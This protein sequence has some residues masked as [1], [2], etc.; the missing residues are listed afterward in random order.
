MGCAELVKKLH[1]VIRSSSLA[2]LWR[3]LS[4]YLQESSLNLIPVC[5][6]INKADDRPER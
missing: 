4:E 3:L 1:L 5:I 2:R 6:S